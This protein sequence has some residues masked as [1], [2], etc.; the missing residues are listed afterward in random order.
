MSS[1]LDMVRDAI[2]D[3]VVKRTASELGTS[4]DLAQ[5]AIET[6][7]PLLVGALGRNAAEPQGAQSLFNALHKDHGSSQERRRHRKIRLLMLIWMRPCSLRPR[8]TL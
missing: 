5:N 8:P 6:A 7:L 1:L 4:P 2:D 3:R